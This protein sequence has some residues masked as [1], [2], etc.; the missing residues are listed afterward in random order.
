MKDVL[1]MI[2]FVVLLGIIPFLIVDTIHGSLDNLN[3]KMTKYIGS[4]IVIERDT[5]LIID[6]S[7]LQNNYTLSNG[8]TISFELAEKLLTPAKVTK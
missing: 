7:V 2:G 6:Y 8:T 3:S 4:K 5:L 1:K